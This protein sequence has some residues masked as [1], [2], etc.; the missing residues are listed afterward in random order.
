[1]AG[2]INSLNLLVVSY[3]Q[4]HFFQCILVIIFLLIS[5]NICF[6]CSLSSF[7]HGSRKIPSGGPEN[8]ILSLQH[9]PQRAVSDLPRETIGPPWV[10]LLLLEGGQYQYK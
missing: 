10:Q 8:F 9:I 2:D 6:G 5:L 1:M 7:M 4:K 3:I